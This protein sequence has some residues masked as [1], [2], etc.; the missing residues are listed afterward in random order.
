MVRR[1]GAKRE[2]SS[3]PASRAALLLCNL[4]LIVGMI[5]AAV[6]Y[7]RGITQQRYNIKKDA[8]CTAVE[9]M[10]QVS[11][12]Y[13][14]TE[15]GYVN[16]WSHYISTQHMTEDEALQ[17]I[18]TLNTQQDRVAHIVD[19]DDFS[20]RTSLVRDN[21]DWIHCYEKWAESDTPADA[22]LLQ[23]M[24]EIFRAD[25]NDVRVLGKYSVGETQQ[26][27]VS[28]GARV[29]LRQADGS[30]KDYLLLRL[31][32][33]E[34][35]QKSWVFPTGYPTAQIGLITREGEYVIQSG[36]MR[37]RSFLDF[38]RDYNF[39]DDYSKIDEIAARL[40]NTDNGLMEYKDSKGQDCY[41]YYSSFGEDTDIDILGF[42]PV[43]DIEVETIDWTIIR[44]ICGTLLLLVFIDGMH[45]LS[46]NRQLHH[47]AELAEKANAAKTQFLSSMSHDI[48]TP[49]NAVIGM[50]EIAKQHLNEPAYVKDCLDKV[51][52]AGNHLLT[53]INDILD[54]SKIES[55][56]MTLDPV[57]FSLRES[58]D[59]MVAIVRQTATEN[60]LGFT[61]QMHDV[62]Q[63]IIVADPLRLRQ[64]LLNLLGNAVKYTEPGGHVRF[65]VSEKAVPGCTDRTRL[66]F[67]I[68]D[69]GIGMSEAFQKTMY[70]SFSRATDSRINK[71]QGSGLGLAIAR[72]MTELMGG[73]IQCE[74]ALG[75]GTTFRVVFEL[76]T[77]SALPM[78]PAPRTEADG[79]PGGLAGM[80]VLAAED[81][82][83]N[84]EI[85]HTMLEEY[86]IVSD[87][88]E[89][90]QICLD[91][92]HDAAAPH[93]DIVLM[94]V[95][96]PVMDGREAT[97]RLRAD[98]DPALRDLP[99]VA[100]TADAFAEDVAACREAGMDAHIAKPV[101]IKQVLRTLKL[102]RDGTLHEQKKS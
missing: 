95:Q 39:A 16:N 102:A 33:V 15:K 31:I 91:I 96:M 51:S 38:I 6:I 99:I 35:L 62:T 97:R 32:P 9:S 101:D 79:T 61:V 45:I 76:P 74:S 67:I 94:D 55:G 84:W 40:A 22:A 8:F 59:E 49:M 52:L 2:H 3:S 77:A 28:V 37:S 63:D 17:F 71:I 11:E 70:T 29:T 23:K 56:R 87:R 41:F 73:E 80:R 18:S 69:D 46:I 34:Y 86:G 13:F 24:R 30:D 4:V 85:I 58:V 66:Q 42:V 14:I 81:N 64:I 92:L 53:L 44:L 20:A 26:T 7:S 72:Q 83:L 90:G 68:T 98:P 10:K 27:V 60:Q 82:D 12:N 47:T 93:Y 36:A 65:D 50:T 48:R 89:N 75:R 57:P 25:Q 43:A 88:A 19:M 1:I 54:I 5:V 21:G 78:Q 100:M